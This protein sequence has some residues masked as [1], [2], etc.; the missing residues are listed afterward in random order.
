MKT[1]RELGLFLFIIA[2]IFLTQPVKAANNCITAT[3]SQCIEDQSCTWIASS[4]TFGMCVYKRE[5]SKTC[6]QIT[7]KDDCVNGR[8]DITGK[9]CAWENNACVY[10]N[11][12]ISCG[13]FTSEETCDGKID[14]F[15]N[16]CKWDSNTE[17]CYKKEESKD[18][19]LDDGP[20]FETISCGGINDIPKPLPSF[21]RAL[22]T[23]IKI[24]VPLILIVMGIIDF[25]KAV[26]SADEKTMNHSPI[27]FIKRLIAA[28]LVFFVISIVQFLFNLI[29]INTSVMGCFRCFI[30]SEE[31]CTEDGQLTTQVANSC[32]QL[33]KKTE[34][35]N[36][37]SSIN[38]CEM[39]CDD[40]IAVCTEEETV[41]K[42]GAN[43]DAITDSNEKKLCK[44]KIATCETAR[45]N[46]DKRVYTYTHRS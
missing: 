35:P 18:E 15:G 43:C 41:C 31:Y 40:K 1:I 16:Y 29:P 24:L 33:C 30:S 5:D 7:N 42:G 37:S 13:R 20:V 36:D 17:E 21:V 9:L 26:I 12:Q 27:S 14:S 23:T 25:L 2:G 34:D 6:P 45:K 10:F 32:K 28:I 3:K 19:D 39:R 4:P 8:A 38:D 22:V 44:E 11:T 46:C